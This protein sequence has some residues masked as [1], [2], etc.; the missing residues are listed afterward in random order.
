MLGAWDEGDLSN[1][2]WA[3]LAPLLPKGK[4]P[5]LATE[6]E[7]TPAHRRDPLAD[8]D[9]G[10]MAGHP[11]SLRAVADRLWLVPALAARRH[12]AAHPDRA[13]SRG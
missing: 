8:P 10:A 2:Q 13:A 11:R 7:Q 6:L 1:E 5:G 12:L 4:K 3:R 9:R